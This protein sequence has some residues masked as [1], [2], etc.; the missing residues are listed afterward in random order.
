MGSAFGERG[1]SNREMSVERAESSQSEGNRRF[2]NGT[3]SRRAKTRSHSR[4][5][6][7]DVAHQKG[8]HNSNMLK[9]ALWN[10]EICLDIN[11]L[12]PFLTSNFVSFTKII[13]D[14]YSAFHRPLLHTNSTVVSGA[15][16]SAITF[17]SIT[18][19][20]IVIIKKIV[21]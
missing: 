12:H 5:A 7:I 14:Y 11:P 16:P 20:C 4:T 13:A 17:I 2:T 3:M 8:F 1:A 21:R 15:Q 19:N 10:F 9:T 18:A 6:V